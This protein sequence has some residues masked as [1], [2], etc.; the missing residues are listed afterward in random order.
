MLTPLKVDLAWAGISDVHDACLRQLWQLTQN[1]ARHQMEAATFR[2]QGYF[3]LLYHET[4][5]FLNSLQEHAS[6]RCLD[7]PDS[8]SF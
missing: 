2:L 1:L 6:C 5:V 3:N 7:D 4:T 8:L